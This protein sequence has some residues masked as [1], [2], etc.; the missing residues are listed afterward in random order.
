MAEAKEN[1]FT[2]EQQAAIDARGRVIVSASA[3]SGKTTV[4]IERIIQLIRSGVSV[5]NILAVT[6]T[7]KAAAQMKEKLSKA[8]IKSIN[9]ESTSAEERKRLKEEL[10]RVGSAD[11]STIHSFCSKLIR[12]HF[13]VADVDNGF[14]VIGSDDADG[15]A[16]QNEALDELLEEGYESSDE[17]FLHL[18]SC[19]WRKKSDN[20]LR[21]IVLTAYDPLRARADYR[22]YLE[23]SKTYDEST[24]DCICADL[25]E[26][27]KHKCEYYYKLI[28]AEL[29]Y[30]REENAR[31]GKAVDRDGEIVVEGGNCIN[32]FKLADELGLWLHDMAGSPDYFSVSKIPKPKLTANR[33]GKK[34]EEEAMHTERLAF[35]RERI[36]KAHEEEFGK[37][38]D[39]DEELTR[40]LQSGKTAAALATYLLKY[41]EIYARMKRERG[42]LDYNDLEHKALALLKNEDIRKEMQ[43]KYAY[44]F[45]DEYQDVNP[46]QDEIVTLVSGEELFL[47][48]DMKQAIYGFRGSNSG[49]FKRKQAEFSNGGTALVMSKNFRS[50]DAV[51]SAVNAQFLL[52]MTE[53]SCGIDYAKEKM[54]KGNMRYPDGCGKVQV[55]FFGTETDK[56]DQAERGVYSVR[57]AYEEGKAEEKSLLSEEIRRIIEDEHNSDFFDVEQGVYRRVEYADIAVLSRKK[58]GAIAKTVAALAASGLPVTAASAV[59]ICE[60]AE[61]KTL[62]DILS[63]LDNAEQD[64]P[65]CSA[66]LS[67]MGKLTADELAD[68]R[69]AY[70]DVKE[71]GFRA[72]CRLY[73]EE[74]SDGIAEKLQKFYAYYRALRTRARVA[75][76]G[77]V[78]TLLLSETGMEGEILA[79]ENGGAALRRV[80]RFIEEATVPE[81]LSV[82]AFLARLR[83]L[84]YDIEFSESGGEDSVKV[85][86][87]HSSKGLEYPVV[88]LD[89]LS[90]NFHAA[91]SDEV[92]AESTYGI[93]PR[94]FDE[95]KMCRYS[96]VLRRLYTVRETERSIADELN[97]Y[98]VAMTRAKYGVHLLFEKSSP[99][100]DVLYA[101]S[102]AEFTDFSVWKDYVADPES[103][104]VRDLVKEPREI[105]ADCPDGE[106]AEEIEHAFL[107]QYPFAGRENLPV[108][109]SAT[110]VMTM[111]P[112]GS[113][114]NEMQAETGMFGK[115]TELDEDEAETQ[116]KPLTKA[117]KAEKEEDRLRG[118]AYH[119]FLQNF[120][121]SLLFDKNGVPMSAMDVKSAVETELATGKDGY[122]K[123]DKN[124]LLR[125][126]QNPVFSELRGAKLYKE[127]DFLVSLSAKDVLQGCKG[128]TAVSGMEQEEVLVQGAIDLL[129]MTDDGV[130]IIDYKYSSGGAAYLQEKYARQLEIYRMATAKFLRQPKEKIR[131]TIINVRR[132]MQVDID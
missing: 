90:A 130:W 107:W 9:D 28:D 54:R 74:K 129:A 87:M 113:V 40:F 12:S 73:A 58:Q 77:E 70:P 125:I 117:E 94:A 29:R 112:D 18:L 101:K 6:F 64:V 118:I 104:A 17:A 26:A 85:L 52:A 55:H 122:E 92:V 32:Q 13:Y 48:G 59:N 63:L 7:K 2:P 131:C 45:V 97:L 80:Q 5:D 1:R 84:E 78:L 62:I 46:V 42:V 81:P 126:L 108:K 66:L 105:Q 71:G 3:G 47:V 10:N 89:N 83:D 119:A 53:E 79:K 61:I 31:T 76:A 121:F 99:I 111:L 20:A 60:F 8:L 49:I 127:Q 41:D 132:G 38:V 50:S 69:L 37:R 116:T 65:L 82:H 128:F 11:I 15:L 19:Y 39:R 103:A 4:M 98:Y 72:A 57:K 34:T 21:R 109:S 51:L 25:H 56:V 93:A 16:L 91:D 68:I 35:L 95:K 115:Q 44:V 75:D 114:A 36:V 22:E 123:L 67:A 102:M 30:F 100:A 120:D 27:F 110:R 33:G 96:T 106:L 23:K 124:V 24:F 14:R 43:E 86:T 88:I